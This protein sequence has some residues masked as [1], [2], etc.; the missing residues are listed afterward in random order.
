MRAVAFKT[1]RVLSTI[2]PARLGRGLM[3]SSGAV[4]KPKDSTDQPVALKLSRSKTTKTV[5]RQSNSSGRTDLDEFRVV[6]C[7][8]TTFP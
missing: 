4:R 5:A 2:G 6:R 1:V 7:T 8:K 3:R